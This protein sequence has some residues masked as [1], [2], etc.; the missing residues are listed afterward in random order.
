LF[1]V[2]CNASDKCISVFKV[3][4]EIWLKEN[5]KKTNKQTVTLRGQSSQLRH[6]CPKTYLIEQRGRWGLD[7]G[8]LVRQRQ[9]LQEVHI[10]QCVL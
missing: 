7:A 4:V 2:S 3:G 5:G 10:G 9:L 8:L 6:I 1:D